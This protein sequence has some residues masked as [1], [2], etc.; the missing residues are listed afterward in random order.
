[1]CKCYACILGHK[2]W[3]LSDEN[4]PIINEP[5]H[6]TTDKW[7]RERTRWWKDPSPGKQE[8]S[9]ECELQAIRSDLTKGHIRIK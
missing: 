1:M 3:M 4:L 2:N 9:K 5:K 8:S 7:G 6:P